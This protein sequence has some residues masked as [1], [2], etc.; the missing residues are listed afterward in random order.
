VLGQRLISA[1]G[2]GL[3]A[4]LAA[5]TLAHGQG[6]APPTRRDALSSA[7]REQVQRQLEAQAKGT[8]QAVA[9]TPAPW[10][11][12]V[13]NE[14]PC[15]RVQH[16]ELLTPDGRANEGGEPLPALPTLPGLPGDLAAFIGPCLGA[17]SLEALRAN[18]DQ[19]L[20]HLGFVTSHVSL[21]AQNL[22]EGTLRLQLHWGRLT[23]VKWPAA[24]RAGNALAVQTGQPLNL[25]DIEQTLENLARLPSQAAQFQ[26]EPGATQGTSMLAM[27]PL[28][29]PGSATARPVRL[30]VG[31]DNAAAREY[32]RWQG[33]LQATVDTPLHLADQLHASINR[34]LGQ[35]GSASRQTAYQLSYFIPWGYQALLLSASGSHHARPVQGLSTRFVENGF[36]TT[37]QARLQSVVWRSASSR[38][39]AWGGASQRRARNHV[40]D[41]ELILQRRRVNTWD[42]GVSGWARWPGGELSVDA[43]QAL[44]TRTSAK[45]DFQLEAHPLARTRRVQ[46]GWSQVLRWGDDT[47]GPGR[48]PTAPL[49]LNYDVNLAWAGVRTPATGADLQ[50]LGS[51]W[52]VRGFDAQ[53]FISGK[54]QFTLKQDLRGP[55]FS[56]AGALQLQPYLALDVGRVAAGVSG[57]GRTLVGTAL[58]L[59]ASGG[60]T[61]GFL[62]WSGDI[63]VATAL[64]KPAGFGAGNTF[65]YCSVNL[66]H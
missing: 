21:P 9:G 37:R 8:P 4:V 33:H 20:A 58:G 7:E 39:L 27:V 41:V 48:Q 65:I 59:R 34:T 66:H 45:T 56:P 25:R 16:I 50:T 23:E 55:A 13:P 46:L 12:P 36:D 22:A 15:F 19:R 5:C 2:V 52:A 32:G 6:V 17:A 40:D 49:A 42:V 1:N 35:A 60:A 11:P 44:S 57:P 38:W 24:G 29:P 43:D 51:R 53:G 31:M 63:A 64:H 14:T 3:L 30:N 61:Q 47:Q 10:R 28:A 18:L 54:E 26:I 62:R